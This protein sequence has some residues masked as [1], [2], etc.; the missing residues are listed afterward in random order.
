MIHVITPRE[1]VYSTSTP[2]PEAWGYQNL[3]T[4]HAFYLIGLVMIWFLLFYGGL[5]RDDYGKINYDTPM[6]AFALKYFGYQHTFDGIDNFLFYSWWYRI[7]YYTLCFLPII[8]LICGGLII[9]DMSERK[10]HK[11]L[12]EHESTS[13]WH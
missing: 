3:R 4:R 7:L 10:L 8:I 11:A 5:G 1:S 13:S 2:I 12:G 9:Y 6:A